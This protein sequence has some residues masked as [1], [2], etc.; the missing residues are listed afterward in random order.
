[1]SLRT[2]V[3][4]DTRPTLV[5]LMGAVS[6]V[7]LIACANVANLL[8]ARGTAR[9][10][11]LAVRKALGATRAR[12][13]RQLL[14]ESLLL[15]AGGGALGILLAVWVRRGLVALAP[16]F[17][18]QSAPGLAASTLEP[19]VL[20]F[21][22]VA[23]L[24][25]T[26]LFG[27]A[28]ALQG[29]RQAASDT[30]K[31]AGR[32]AISGPRSLRLRGALVVSEIALAMVLLVG[33]GLMIRTLAELHRVALGF[34]P[35]R[36]LT[37][38]VT[39][40]GERYREPQARAEFWRRVTAAVEALPSVEAASASRGLPMGGLVGP[41]LHDRR[42]ARSPRRP[43]ARRQLRRGG[44]GLLP[45]AA[46]PDPQGTRF[47]R[48][49]RP[50]RAAVAIV[51][52]ELAR[53]HWPGEDPLG[54][55]LRIGTGADSAPGP[56]LTVIGVAGNIMTQGPEYGAHAEIYVPYMQPWLMGPESLLVR[57]AADPAGLARAVEDAVHG[58]GRG[59]AG[60]GHPDDGRGRAGADGGEAHGDGAAR[61]LR[62]LAF[63]L[64][65]LGI[66]SVLSY[67]VAQRTREIGLR[68]A[69]GARRGDVVRLV[70]G[71]GAR[72]VGFGLGAGTVFA[73]ALSRVMADLLYDVR[74]TDPATF[75]A[76]ALLLGAASLARLL[77]S[78]APG[79]RRRAIRS[80]FDA[81]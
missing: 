1:M 26:L 47:R 7:L 24:A 38:R 15:A 59:A 18:V 5:V 37:L 48:S 62:G 20:G 32:A 54:K 68:M 13:F 27:A 51:N 79:V 3:S 72:L 74:A 75:A 11:E 56:W 63:L 19:R 33:A 81:D 60:G 57:A 21:T 77:S 29:A 12:L 49:R 46:D 65:A 64:S 61:W 50:E 6:F 36:V 8:L 10:G 35:A 31:E 67:A 78:R 71:R 42:A 9:A 30:L 53:L 69:L 39:L 17:L 70:A 23:S 43:G 34:D 44:A 25:T 66:Y 4:G 76:V 40:T 80:P 41:I 14:T 52:E 2:L 16:P 45:C 28:P 22:L 55:R 58:V 73:L